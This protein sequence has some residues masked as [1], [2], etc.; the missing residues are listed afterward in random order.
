MNS[1]DFKFLSLPCNSPVENAAIDIASAILELRD[2]VVELREHM[3]TRD[4]G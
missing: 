4:R 3:E 1:D 2:A